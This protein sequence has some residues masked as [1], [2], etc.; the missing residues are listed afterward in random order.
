MEGLKGLKR[1]ETCILPDAFSFPWRK[2][3][4]AFVVQS[5]RGQRRISKRKIVK[6]EKGTRRTGK[7]VRELPASTTS[8]V[9]SPEFSVPVAFFGTR[10]RNRSEERKAIFVAA[11]CDN[12]YNTHQTC[13]NRARAS[14][15]GTKSKDVISVS[16]VA[17]S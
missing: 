16:L 2:F 3:K 6:V 17:V 9:Q 12:R 4:V 14:I 13:T 15:E 1:F 7:S 5:A 11:K 10:G 8:I